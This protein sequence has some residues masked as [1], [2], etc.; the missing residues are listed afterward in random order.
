LNWSI[1]ISAGVFI[2]VAACRK[3]TKAGIRQHDRRIPAFA[4]KANSEVLPDYTVAERH[5]RL[6]RLAAV[7]AAADTVK[8]I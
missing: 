5:C 8:G 2:P 3:Y 7:A 1:D 4:R 6:E